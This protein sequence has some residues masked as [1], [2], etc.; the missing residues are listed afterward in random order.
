MGSHRRVVKQWCLTN[1][2]FRTHSQWSARGLRVLTEAPFKVQG[3]LQQ[4]ICSEARGVV[5]LLSILTSHNLFTCFLLA[6]ALASTLFSPMVNLNKNSSSSSFQICLSPSWNLR[7]SKH[8]RSP[9][10]PR[11]T[12]SAKT[13][14]ACVAYYT[15]R[16]KSDR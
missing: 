7:S 11:P 5:W 2:Q 8:D 10:Q 6:T 14:L 15:E 1:H 9:T 16:T 4:R 3:C 13:C 12:V